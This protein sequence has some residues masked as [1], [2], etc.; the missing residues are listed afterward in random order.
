MLSKDNRDIVTALQQVPRF[1]KL[2]EADLG[3]VASQ[4]RHLTVPEHWALMTENTPADKAYLVIRGEA[5]VRQRGEE[6]ARVG[7]GE[8]IGEIALVNHKLRS[9]TVVAE[10]PLEVL[11]F[12]TEDVNALS[13][14]IPDF[15]AVLTASAAERLARDT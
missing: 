4:S 11:H 1:S 9:A 2:S 13:E 14:Q 8:L 15:E 10:T 3:Q 12:T 5:S 6:I 7:P